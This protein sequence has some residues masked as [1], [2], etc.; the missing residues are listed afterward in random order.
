MEDTQ[1]RAELLEAAMSLRSRRRNVVVWRQSADPAGRYRVRPA[2]GRRIRRWI[3]ASVLLTIVA[4]MPLARAVRA[5]W[6]PLLAGAALTAAGIVLRGSQA[7]MVLLPGLLLLFSAPLIPGRPQPDRSQD[8]E[9]ERE[10][11][12]FC[13]PAQ[14]RDIEATLDR[15]PDDITGQLRDIL[16]RQGAPDGRP[17]I[18]G[19]GRT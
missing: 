14:R 19:C 10:L 5:R 1:S 13:T 11:A 16:A 6:R 15:Y 17:G 8:A 3:R 4:L 2:R 7:S 9:L 18:P 12:V